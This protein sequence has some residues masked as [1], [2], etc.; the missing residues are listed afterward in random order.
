MKAWAR[1]LVCGAVGVIAGT[2]VATWAVRAG[3]M[4]SGK[5]IGAWVSGTDFGSTEQ[6]ALTRAVVARRGLLALPAREAR[7]YTASVDDAGRPLEGRCRYRIT[8]G[9]LPAKWWSLTVYDRDGYLAGPGPWSIGSVAIPAAERDRWTIT[10][11]PNRQPD[12]WLPTTGLDRFDLTLRAYLPD[13]AGRTNPARDQLPSIR[14]EAC[15]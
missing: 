7:Y 10:L 11:A 2:G 9:A 13:N 8:G 15:A 5:P 3:A 1:Y 4:S 6:S 12:K 14:R